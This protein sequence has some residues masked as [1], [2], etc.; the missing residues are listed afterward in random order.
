VDSVSLHH[1]KLKKHQALKE[2][3][4]VYRIFIKAFIYTN[5][6]G[7]RNS[8]ANKPQMVELEGRK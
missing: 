5:S 4:A 7:R 1:K 6:K 3:G 8:A 2:E